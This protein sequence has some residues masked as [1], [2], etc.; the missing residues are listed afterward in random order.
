MVN[1]DDV[2]VILEKHQGHLNGITA[3]Q[4]ALQLGVEKRQVRHLVTELRLEGR[5]VCGQPKT[6]YFI[7]ATG[8]DVEN[9]CAFLR[10]RAMHS[11]MLE[12]RLRKLTLGELLGQ[13]RLPT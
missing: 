9:T 7:A 12:S 13:M 2:L 8:E 5:A 6:G 10:S 1:K 3:E 11:L 4:L